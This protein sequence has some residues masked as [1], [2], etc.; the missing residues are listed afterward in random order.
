MKGLII[1]LF[2][3]FAVLLSSC[4][5]D[6]YKIIK[7]EEEIIVDLKIK[8]LSEPEYGHFYGYDNTTGLKNRGRRERYNV[9]VGQVV[10]VKLKYMVYQSSDNGY[11]VVYEFKNKN[12]FI[13]K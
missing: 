1:I 4:A 11:D 3:M 9:S 7:Q 2:L 6:R 13:K 10:K 12:E 5:V 8:G